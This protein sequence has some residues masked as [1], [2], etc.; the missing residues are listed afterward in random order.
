MSLGPNLV[1]AVQAQGQIHFDAED[2][3]LAYLLK[4]F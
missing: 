4:M 2:Q 3:V 1:V